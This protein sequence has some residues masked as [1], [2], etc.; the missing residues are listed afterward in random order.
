LDS[1]TIFF[2]RHYGLFGGYTNLEDANIA[3]IGN[4]STGPNFFT[5]ARTIVPATPFVAYGGAKIKLW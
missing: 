5:N 4:P 3:S 2:D 1:S